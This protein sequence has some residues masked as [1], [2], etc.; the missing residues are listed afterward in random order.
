MTPDHE[1]ERDD[2]RPIPTWDLPLK[3]HNVRCED[4][5]HRDTREADHK[6]QLEALPNARDYT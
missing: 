3:R 4:N 2:Q 6:G 1:R 5:H